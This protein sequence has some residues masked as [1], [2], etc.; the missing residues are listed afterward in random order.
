MRIREEPRQ[1][2]PKRARSLRQPGEVPPP[3]S[4]RTRE[5]GPTAVLRPHKTAAR[6]RK[7]AYGFAV[8]SALPR[9]RWG[10]VR[11]SGSRVLSA[12]LLVAMLVL[13]GWFFVD[14]GFF[15]Y[16]AQ[17]QGNSLLSAEDLFQASGLNTLSVF[18]VD[19]V[20]VA[21]RIQQAIP[22]VTIARVDVQWPNQVAIS[23]RE[24][25]VRFVW[26]NAAESFLVDGMGRVLMAD[27]GAHAEMLTVNDLDNGPLKPGDKVDRVGLNAV[28]GLHSLLPEVKAFDYSQAKGVSFV[29]EH[30][31]RIY[32]GDD[33]LLV[34]K[35]ACMRALLQDIAN[36]GATVE[37]I[38][39]RFVDGAYF[40]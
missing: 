19:R 4:N 35:V 38:D 27:D 37:F 1:T 3:S 15:V 31:W 2:Q 23:V 6:R 11:I 20:Q 29:D 28:S 8:S 26:R 13:L 25:D 32:F 21:Q 9:L 40:K 30:G 24:Q 36:K 34:K 39:V 22:G 12:L 14:P 16:E 5:P 7:S 10:E 33:Q 17:V 18:F